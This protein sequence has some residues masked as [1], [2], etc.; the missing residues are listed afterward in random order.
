MSE[1]NSNFA[2]APFLF[3]PVDFRKKNLEKKLP[4]DSLLTRIVEST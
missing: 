2:E 3:L 1:F 4:I